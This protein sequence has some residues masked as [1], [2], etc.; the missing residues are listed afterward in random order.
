ME[1]IVWIDNAREFSQVVG[2]E[3]A[4]LAFARC[5]YKFMM[6]RDAEFDHSGHFITFA[7]RHVSV[8]MLGVITQDMYDITRKE[9]RH[10]LR[11][12]LPDIS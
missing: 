2:Q 11:D 12:H 3:N 9:V 7:N 6:G 1:I 10:N 4:P 5:V 8:M